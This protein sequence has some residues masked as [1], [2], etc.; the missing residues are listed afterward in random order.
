[1]VR[2]SPRQAPDPSLSVL[3]VEDD[4]DARV[5]LQRMIQLL[6]HR[7]LVAADVDEAEATLRV[8]DIDAV[9]SDWNLATETGLDLC[10]WVRA[11]EH[12]RA[13]Y[14]LVVSGFSDPE[15]LGEAL[16]AGADAFLSK[17]LDL[18]ELEANLVTAASVVAERKLHA[19]T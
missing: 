2:S 10:R 19:A 16:S 9:V 8:Q 4:G 14:F 13:A 12:R 1:M 5:L 6:G 11:D 7:C 18:S 15:H 3:V 17:P